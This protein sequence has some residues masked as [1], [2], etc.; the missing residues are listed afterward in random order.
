MTGRVP[1]AHDVVWVS[2]GDAISFLDGLVSQAVEPMGEGSVARGLLLSPQGKL[3]AP[4]WLLRDAHR[5]G[6]VTDHGFGERVAGDLARYR[7]RVDVSIAEDPRP[8]TEVWGN[9]ARDLVAADRFTNDGDLVVDLPFISSALPRILTT[10]LHGFPLVSEGEAEAWR[11]EH[12]EPRF[13]VD[14]DEATIPQEAGLVEDA[15]D[16][17]KG[18]Y[19]G[20]ELVA[21]IESRGH[22]NRRLRGLVLSAAVEP[23]SS[24][25]HAGDVVGSVTSVATS[26]RLGPVA[27]AMVRREIEPGELA[28]VGSA[29]GV[30]HVL[31]LTGD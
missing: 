4:L 7:I 29:D 16:F 21:R 1:D 6:I 13:G 2:G 31:P 28:R 30:V 11:I 5:V 3:R 14:I 19:L 20:Q 26:D 18:C 17:T 15:V 23:G 27:L 25:V 24:V 12:G 9:A 22:V 8:V 10:G